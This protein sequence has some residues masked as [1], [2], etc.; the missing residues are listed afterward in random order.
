MCPCSLAAPYRSCSGTGR[1]SPV[2][3]TSGP[4]AHSHYAPPT[5]CSAEKEQEHTENICFIFLQ[6]NW[7]FKTIS[8]I[9]TVI[10]ENE[11]IMLK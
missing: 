11:I 1:R 10:G 9:I 8:K 4:P 3:P 6:T 2:G 7:F 5:P